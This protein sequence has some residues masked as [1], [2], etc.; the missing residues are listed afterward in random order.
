M[1]GGGCALPGL[2]SYD[3]LLIYSP[4]LLKLP[5]LTASKSL[6]HS[7]KAVAVSGPCQRSAA[8]RFR[9]RGGAGWR[10]KCLI[11]PTGSHHQA[12]T[13]PC[14]NAALMWLTPA[15]PGLLRLA[16]PAMKQR[17]QQDRPEGG[18]ANPAQRKA[19]QRQREIAGAQHRSPTP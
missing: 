5:V 11:R 12:H 7:R 17:V 4:L 18:R 6:R 9:A 16:R 3:L 14:A 15:L 10:H 2:R 19:A 13:A 1:P 8:V